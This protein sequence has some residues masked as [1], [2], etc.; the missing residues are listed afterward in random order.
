MTKGILVFCRDTGFEY[1]KILPTFIFFA[2]KLGLPISV[3]T[4]KET[5]PK[6]SHPNKIVFD[7]KRKTFRITNDFRE[8]WKNF[9]RSRSYDL[10]PYEKTLVLDI[11]YLIQTTDLLSLFES[12]RLSVADRA[13][14][15]GP[16]G[17]TLPK[18]IG[19]LKHYWATV[20]Y[21]TKDHK[22][23]F[24]LVKTVENNYEY[25]LKLFG[26]T[27]TQYRND[28]VFSIAKHYWDGMSAST[29]QFPYTLKFANHSTYI[30]DYDSDKTRLTMGCEWNGQKHVSHV[31]DDLHVMN[32]K[33]LTKIDNFLFEKGMRE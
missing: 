12:N 32:K 31:F 28:Y 20:F 9:G 11:D 29:Q 8:D 24:D 22:D 23:F 16:F 19:N 15:I 6:I 26:I 13:E 5:S 14:I 17:L 25:Y 27:G 10:T 3:V 21:F 33:E 18:K 4:D 7:E 2:S 1:S 30:L